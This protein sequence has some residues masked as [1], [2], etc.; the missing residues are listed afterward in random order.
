MLLSVSKMKK[1]DAHAGVQHIVAN[2]QL[3]KK[4]ADPVPEAPT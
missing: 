2:I 4:R 1:H 3:Q